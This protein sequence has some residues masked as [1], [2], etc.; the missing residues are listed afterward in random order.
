MPHLWLYACGL[1]LCLLMLSGCSDASVPKL[2]PHSPAQQFVAPPHSP[3]SK[4]QIVTQS[5]SADGSKG[6][7]VF[8]NPT[9]IFRCQILPLDS[10]LQELKFVI[11]KTKYWEG[12][13]FRP[14][15][16]QEIDLKSQDGVSIVAVGDDCVISIRGAA[17]ETLR[18]GGEFQFINQ[19]R[20]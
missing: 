15:E 19:Y 6:E 7:V 9:G 14:G 10:T 8:D 18:P 5:A 2:P 16:S 1:W 3:G 20:N 4:C 17:L 12:V 11:R 13:S